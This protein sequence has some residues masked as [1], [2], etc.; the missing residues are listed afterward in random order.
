MTGLEISQILGWT[1]TTLFTSML[2]PQILKTI[3]TKST[4][5]VSL[6][7]FVVY[8]LANIVA[9]IYAVLIN[10]YPLMIKYNL[11]IIISIFY[12]TIY[13]VYYAK[14]RK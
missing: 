5:G 14:E 10:Q 12:L 9:L 2:I 11:A 13:I 8:L 3:K 1:A 4:K 7:L 6:A